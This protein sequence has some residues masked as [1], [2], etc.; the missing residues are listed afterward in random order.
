MSILN[1]Y[2]RNGYSQNGEDG[3]IEEISLRLGIKF[4]TFVEFGAWDGKHLSNTYNLLEHGWNGV[5]IEADTKKF[6]DLIQNMRNFKERVT[7][8][9]AFVEIEGENTLDNLLA[10]TDL[11]PE[12]DLL[13]IDIDSYDWQVWNSLVSYS[14]KI[15]IIEIN[16][17]IP[18][19]VF[20]T[21]RNH[22]K[23]QGSSFTATVYLGKKKGYTPVCHTGNLI[24]VRNDLVEKLMLPQDEI[25]FPE[26]LFNY[27]W[28]R[29]NWEEPIPGMNRLLGILGKL[30]RC[31]VLW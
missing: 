27:K 31:L 30:R 4:G 25:N 17:S 7:T 21:H 9:Q 28:K 18:V 26:L 22:N 2:L 1:K 15:V 6:N 11:P 3:V 13:S 10:R 16:S 14:P 24:F 12:F 20:Q 23:I 29:I 8:I 5:Y 19:G